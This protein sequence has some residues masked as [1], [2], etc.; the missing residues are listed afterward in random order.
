M[1]S[2]PRSITLPDGTLLSEAQ[3]KPVDGPDMEENLPAQTSAMMP[4]GWN[5]I[6]YDLD[7]QNGN[8]EPL[9][10]CPKAPARDQMR[11]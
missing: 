6:H 5:F 10:L 4:P 11:F 3:W 8:M 7:P 1:Y 9:T 2:P